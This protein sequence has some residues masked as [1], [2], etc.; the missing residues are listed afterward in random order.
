MPAESGSA[1][2]KQKKICDLWPLTLCL[3]D[4]FSPQI[5]L[6]R[7]FLDRYNNESC[8]KYRMEH[9]VKIAT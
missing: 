8:L 5:R 4:K 3:F 6:I 7:T 2:K 1:A 9:C